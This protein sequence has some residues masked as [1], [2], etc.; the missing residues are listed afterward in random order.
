MSTFGFGSG[1][2]AA[3][4]L[5]R[6][7]TKSEPNAKLKLRTADLVSRRNLAVWTMSPSVKNFSLTRSVCAYLIVVTLLAGLSY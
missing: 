7:R 6:A 5:K 4:R 2:A 1:G 3:S